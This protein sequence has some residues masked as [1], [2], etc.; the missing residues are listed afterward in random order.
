MLTKQLFQK[1]EIHWQKK[2]LCQMT[3]FFPIKK[4]KISR[5]K[6]QKYAKHSLCKQLP[7]PR[8]KAS[9]FAQLI[10][11][12]SI[13][14]KRKFPPLFLA[15]HDDEKKNHFFLPL[16]SLPQAIIFFSSEWNMGVENWRRCLHTQAT[17]TPSSLSLNSHEPKES[18]EILTELVS[19]TPTE[20]PN[21]F[22]LKNK[23]HS[24]CNRHV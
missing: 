5:K 19:G 13:G 17:P 7:F 24:F 8:K 21:I 2:I 22:L 15:H 16:L 4:K 10:C 12:F 23:P 6:D 1:W 18:G 20:F 11:T 14:R 9:K 3:H